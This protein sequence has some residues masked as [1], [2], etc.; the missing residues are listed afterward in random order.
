MENEDIIFNIYQYLD[1]KNLLNCSLVNKLFYKKF[2]SKLIWL[3]QFNENLYPNINEYK[4]LFNIN[5][6]KNIYIKCYTIIKLINKIPYENQFEKILKFKLKA[7]NNKIYNHLIDGIK[8]MIVN[9]LDYQ[10]NWQNIIIILV[11][12]LFELDE[13]NK[14]ELDLILNSING[15]DLSYYFNNNINVSIFN[16]YALETSI[17]QNHIENV[18][19]F[20]NNDIVPEN[21][22]LDQAIQMGYYDI[23]EIILDKYKHRYDDDYFDKAMNLAIF[24][25]RTDII[26]LLI[27][28]GIK[29]S[30]KGYM[31]LGLK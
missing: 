17:Q 6:N 31:I 4:N 22:L 5:T 20:L 1:L 19:L 30:E 27:D 25:S 23:V 16:N 11:K 3:E 15:K 12:L 7:K 21:D 18:K 8:Y 24:H 29:P 2:N 28:F 9:R 10:F 26:N 14:D 13:I